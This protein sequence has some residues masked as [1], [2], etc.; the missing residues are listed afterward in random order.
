[1]LSF[2]NKFKH[3]NEAFFIIHGFSKRRWHALDPLINHLE[4]QGFNVYYPAIYDPLNENDND[5]KLWI[6][7]VIEKAHI[8]AAKHKHVYVIGFSM[9][10]VIASVVA[11]KIKVKRLILLAPAFEY[12]TFENVKNKVVKSLLPKPTTTD[13]NFIALPFVF[14]KTFKEIVR[15]NKDAIRSVGCPLL[16][17]HGTKDS[18]IPLNSSYFA[19]EKSSSFHKQLICLEGVNHNLVEDV[20][21]QHQIFALIESFAFK[22]IQE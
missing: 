11:S 3:R 18:R 22:H 2:I 4:S 10:G 14:E 5:A 20:T 16:V 15:E 12:I 21:Y 6:A 19:Y 13:Y 17:I 8:V 9:G 1:M 7:R